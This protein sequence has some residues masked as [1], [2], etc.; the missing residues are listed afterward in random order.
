MSDVTLTAVGLGREV[1]G[2]F[3]RV[4]IPAGETL[5][6]WVSAEDRK[7]L[8][9]NGALGPKPKVEAAVVDEKDARIAELES[10]LAAAEAAA[11]AAKSAEGSK[12]K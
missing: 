5:P 2:S 8:K 4:D 10:Q 3:Q 11:E 12:D 1:N 6:S 9:A 7:A